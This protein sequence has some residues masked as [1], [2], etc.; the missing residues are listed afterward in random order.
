MKVALGCLRLPPR[1]PLPVSGRCA[2][3][4]FAVLGFAAGLLFLVGV[5]AGGGSA[6]GLGL[7]IFDMHL[8]ESVDSP[9]GA[10]ALEAVLALRPFCA[11]V[12]ASEFVFRFLAEPVL[13]CT[14]VGLAAFGCSCAL[15]TGYASAR[16]RA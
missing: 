14:L 13:S 12:G 2:L 5:D 15:L 10:T 8:P 4:L 1:L 3:D 11:R 9:V 16:A 7:V 6:T